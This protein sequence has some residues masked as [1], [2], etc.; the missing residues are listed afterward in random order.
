METPVRTYSTNK[1][2]LIKAFKIGLITFLILAISLLAI[3]RWKSDM[4]MDKVLASVQEQLT[5]SL[6]YSEAGMDWFSHF[7]ST[8]IQINNLFLGS[9][10]T[11]LIAGGDVDIVISLLSLLKGN[12]AIRQLHLTNS[13]IHIHQ[14]AGKW[15]YEIMKESETSND[16]SFNNQIT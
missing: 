8:A 12:I 13:T 3:M 11:P 2:K 10:K 4:I 15:S 5:D 7:P 14:H 6:R 1:E 16:G 9:G